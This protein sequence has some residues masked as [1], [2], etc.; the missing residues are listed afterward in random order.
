[1]FDHINKVKALAYQLFCLEVGVKDENV[2]MTLFESFPPS[3]EYLITT[4][5]NKS[6]KEFT[7]EYVIA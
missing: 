3:Y 4:L 7:L 5:K 1:M 2:V 6:M